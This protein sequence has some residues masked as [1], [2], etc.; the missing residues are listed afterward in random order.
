MKFHNTFTNEE[1]EKLK[2]IYEFGSKDLIL[3]N[4]PGRDYGTIKWKASKLGLKKKRAVQVESDLSKLLNNSA[5][6]FYWIGFLMADGYVDHKQKRISLAISKLDELHLSKFAN[7]IN[8]NN[9]NFSS[10]KSKSP[11]GKIYIKET[12]QIS[13]A[14]K[15]IIPQIIEK[16]NFKPKKT[17]NPPDLNCLNNNINLCISFIIGFI[18]GDGT[19]STSKNN[20]KLCTLAIRCHTSWLN[21]LQYFSDK[22]CNEINIPPKKAY[23]YDNCAVIQMN[24]KMIKHLYNNII[25]LNLP[26]LERKWKKIDINFINRNEQIEINKNKAIE[27]MNG[28]YT[29]KDISKLCNF[30]YKYTYQLVKR[31]LK[32]NCN[33][34]IK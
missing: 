3:S 25:K 34:K 13:A 17:Y 7:F 28:N 18:D 21:N 23:I 24:T 26:I 15:Y 22:I 11:S 16:F 4:L 2:K 20:S 5:E 31:L 12:C 8:C 19:I 27:L 6:A 29:I 1:I 10:N 14:D 33:L 9:I 30:E 32:T